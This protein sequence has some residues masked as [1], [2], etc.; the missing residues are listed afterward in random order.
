MQ[1]LED[2][3]K[4]MNQ[5]VTTTI[6]DDFLPFQD[7][8]LNQKPYFMKR[9]PSMSHYLLNADKMVI[10]NKFATAMDADL[11][12]QKSKFG[13]LVLSK[14]SDLEQLAVKH[15]TALR[16]SLSHLKGKVESKKIA[17]PQIWNLIEDLQLD[18]LKAPEKKSP[19]KKSAEDKQPSNVDKIRE[20]FNKKKPVTRKEIMDVTGYDSRN[21]HTAMGI[22][23]NPA[24]T[25][26]PLHT[27]Y[28]RKT[29]TY[30]KVDR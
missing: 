2:H 6:L 16:G 21:A 22:L 11:V 23:K 18:A 9:S 4:M 7:L 24:R 10:V 20:L 27:E 5:G 19:K 12:G 15:L 8:P 26:K 3:L 25:S 29:Q 28:D 1:L 17:C 14:A 30:T 13:Y